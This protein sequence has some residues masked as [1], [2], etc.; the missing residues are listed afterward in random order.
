MLDAAGYR[1]L[2][3]VLPISAAL[4]RAADRYDRLLTAASNRSRYFDATEH[5]EFLY[6][7]VEKTVEH[8]LPRVVRS[9][10][11]APHEIR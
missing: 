5:A 7:C 4:A 10:D 1:P 3:G 9:L 11:A 2:A 8:D 6:S